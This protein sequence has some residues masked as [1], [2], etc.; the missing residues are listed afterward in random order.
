VSRPLYACGGKSHS[1]SWSLCH[2]TSAEHTVTRA[3][4]HIYQVFDFKYYPVFPS[5]FDQVGALSHSGSQVILIRQVTVRIPTEV[6]VEFVTQRRSLA[7]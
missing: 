6:L 5:S 7:L 1:P 3:A 4:I 2:V